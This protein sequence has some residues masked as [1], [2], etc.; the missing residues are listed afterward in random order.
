MTLWTSTAASWLRASY[1]PVSWGDWANY[2]WAVIVLI[3]QHIWPSSWSTGQC[4]WYSSGCRSPHQIF[5]SHLRPK[6]REQHCAVGGQKGFTPKMKL[7]SLLGTSSHWEQFSAVQ[8]NGLSHCQ[9]RCSALLKKPRWS[10]GKER[11]FGNGLAR[12]GK[13]SCAPPGLPHVGTTHLGLWVV[14]IRVSPP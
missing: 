2:G 13:F 11:Q 1:S 10:L 12:G 6:F 9:A 8:I 5:V 7:I 3:C 4:P 14:G